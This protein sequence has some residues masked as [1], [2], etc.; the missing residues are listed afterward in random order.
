M[1]KDLCG[2]HGCGTLGSEPCWECG[3]MFCATHITHSSKR[4]GWLICHNCVERHLDDRWVWRANIKTDTQLDPYEVAIRQSV[5]GVGWK[6]DN[7]RTGMSWNSYEKKAQECYRGN[8]KTWKRH[9]DFL[10][11]RLATG[12]FVWIRDKHA[13]FYLGVIEGPW[14]YVDHEENVAADLVNVRRCKWKPFGITAA[15]GSVQEA[16]GLFRCIIDSE[17]YE[18]VLNYSTLLYYGALSGNRSLLTGDGGTLF[19]WLSPSACE[20]FV[21]LYLQSERGYSMIPTTCKQSTKRFEFSLIHRDTGEEAAVQ[22]KKGRSCNLNLESYKNDAFQVFVFVH[23]G[24][25]R[26]VKP[27]NVE[28]VSASDLIGFAQ[29]KRTILPPTIRVWVDYFFP[30]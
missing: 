26:G 1:S 6:V 2:E 18:P 21:G 19:T 17:N 22:V 14:E 11:K 8:I 28:I 12:D 24:K 20:D 13:Q 30:A 7:G 15:P 4:L 27:E 23:G 10:C 29:R 5:F 25:Y 3:K 9:M 16:R